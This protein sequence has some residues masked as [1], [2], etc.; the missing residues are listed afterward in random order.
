MK[1]RHPPIQRYALFAITLLV[2]VTALVIWVQR[3]RGAASPEGQRMSDFDRWLIGT[4]IDLLRASDVS[5]PVSNDSMPR[6]FVVAPN[7]SVSEIAERLQRQGL[8]RDANLFRLYVRLRG[9]D[10][11]IRAGTFILRPSMSMEQIALALQRSTANEVQVTIPEGLRREEIADRL[12]AEIGLSADAFRAATSRASA[13]S[14]PFLQGLPADATL[15][16]FLFPDTYRLPENPTAQDVVLRMLDNFAVKA[17]PLLEQ[18]RA[19]GKD[20]YA[21]LIV[22]SIVEREVVIPAERPLIAS[23]YWNRLRVGQPLQADPT[24][25]YAL[26]YQPDQGTWWKRNLTLEDLRYADPAGYNTYVNPSL[27]P[28][29]ISNPGRASIEAALRPA[30]TDFFYFVASCSGDGSHQFSVT[31]AE[32]QSKLCR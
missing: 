31:F 21:V 5:R 20:P 11:T 13:Y 30:Q 25:Q 17:A 10:T 15:E 32:H 26:G 6:V 22:A 19:E 24:T 7:E 12:E 2:L 4:Y 29:P 9:L 1:R 16:G 18:A 8:I 28:G 27:P 3:V 23:V 14:Y